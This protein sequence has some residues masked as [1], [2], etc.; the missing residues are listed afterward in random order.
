MF[1]EPERDPGTLAS[2]ATR[3]LD[4]EVLRWFFDRIRKDAMEALIS[5]DA[6]DKTMILRLQ[7]RC[8]AIDEIRDEMRMAV[9]R[10]A[11]Q[12]NPKRTFA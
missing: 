11:D 4:D 6:D 5:A 7:Q 12:A 2:E 9:R 10:M 8:A 3:L 1:F